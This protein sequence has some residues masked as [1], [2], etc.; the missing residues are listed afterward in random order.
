[1]LL[2][3]KQIS[4][5]YLICGRTDLRRGIDGLT[6][7]VEEQYHLDPHCRNLYLF[8]GSRKDRFKALYWAGDG[9]ILLYKRYENG[10]LQWPMNQAAAKSLTHQQL[11]RLLTGWSIEPTIHSVNPP[12]KH[13]QQGKEVVKSSHR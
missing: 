13:I 6:G 10:R 2:D 8:C 11:I 5:V 3:L 4:E 9:F 1:M 12:Q 7:I